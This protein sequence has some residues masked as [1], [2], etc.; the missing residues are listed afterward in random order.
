[1]KRLIPGF[2]ILIFWAGCSSDNTPKGIIRKDDM[3]NLITDLQLVDGYIA[4]LPQD[5]ANKVG[6]QLYLSAFKKYNTDSTR[7]TRSLKYYS[8]QPKTLSEVYASVKTKLDTLEKVEERRLNAETLKAEKEITKA[9]KRRQDSIKKANGENK[10]DSILK[11]R[12]TRPLE[13]S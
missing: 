12:I 13:I 9:E 5:S 7:F 6:P 8:L 4:G 10:A 2:L 3:T 11:K 1:M